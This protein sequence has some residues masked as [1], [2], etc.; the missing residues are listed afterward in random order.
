M[1]STPALFLYTRGLASRS[2]RL[3]IG[4]DCVKKRKIS[5]DV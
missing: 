5:D 1:I 2:D 4:K 3:K